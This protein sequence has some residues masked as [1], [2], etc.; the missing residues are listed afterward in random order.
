MP[1]FLPERL[2]SFEFFGGDEDPEY[3]KEAKPYQEDI[4]F[5]FFAVNLGYSYQEYCDLTPRQRVFIYK[6]YENK[7]I[8]EA[9]M[10]YNA[11]FTATYNVNRP[12]R[13]KALKPLERR[14]KKV[15]REHVAD[16]V[17]LAKEIDQKEGRKWYE[18]I[19]RAN[20]MKKG[21]T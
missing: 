18:K 14:T 5:A 12:K 3:G 6:A 17:Q 16:T 8:T 9:M 2:I 15:D 10:I 11:V 21:G 1:F 20:G 4:D 19:L 13:K 7:Y